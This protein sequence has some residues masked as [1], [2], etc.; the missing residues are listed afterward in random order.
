MSE[1]TVHALFESPSLSVRDTHCRGS[2]RHASDEECTARTM[3]VF[4]YRGTYVRH[5]G[6]DQAVG[7]ANQ[8]LFFN[9][10][11]G[12]RV[13]HP[14]AGGD[15]SITLDIVPEELRALIPPAHLREGPELAFRRQRL[16]IDAR[17]QSMAAV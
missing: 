4:P 11:E 12:Y 8:V 6:R 7:E 13:S 1:L 2:C 5:V 3:L 16:R 17:A 15:A 14:V 9:A 10:G